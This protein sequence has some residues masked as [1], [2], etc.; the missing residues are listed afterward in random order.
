M[1]LVTWSCQGDYVWEGKPLRLGLRQEYAICF[2]LA[3]AIVRPIAHMST[4]TCMRLRDWESF[5]DS[6][7]Q[8][9]CGRDASFALLF[10]LVYRIQHLVSFG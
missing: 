1:G 5:A 2:A 7:S 3:D 9:A 6:S 10:S 4:S 8:V